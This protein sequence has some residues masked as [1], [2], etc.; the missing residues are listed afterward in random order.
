LK[1]KTMILKNLFQL[2][3]SYDQAVIVLV[4]FVHCAYKN[5]FGIFVW[6]KNRLLFFSGFF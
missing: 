3:F 1:K 2:L 6:R 4:F 5:A